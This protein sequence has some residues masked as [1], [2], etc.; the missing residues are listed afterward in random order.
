M[1]YCVSRTISVCII[2]WRY[3]TAISIQYRYYTILFV[4][5]AQNARW[6]HKWCMQY[7]DYWYDIQNCLPGDAFAAGAAMAV[8]TCA[9]RSCLLFL[10][11]AWC[12]MVWTALS[13]SWCLFSHILYRKL[14][15]ITTKLPNYT[16]K[17]PNTKIRAGMF[18][19]C[20]C[21]K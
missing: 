11:P 16:T 13:Q 12:W 6:R 21:P 4:Q 19:V 15:K 2:A 7:H 1:L 9:H 10:C 8:P 18:Y 5:I 3:R 17:L 14:L 20:S